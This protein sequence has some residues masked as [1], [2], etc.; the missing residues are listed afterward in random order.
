M[1]NKI[2]KARLKLLNKIIENLDDNV[3]IWDLQAY[4]NIVEQMAGAHDQLLE[5]FIE[6]SKETGVRNDPRRNEHSVF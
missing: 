2:N 5:L 4:A 1:N 6:L 3:S